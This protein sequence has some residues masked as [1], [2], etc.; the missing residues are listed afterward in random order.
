MTDPDAV[1][2]RFGQLEHQ[3]HV[4]R[5]AWAAWASTEAGTPDR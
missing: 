5:E 3:E 4:W 1:R 2:E